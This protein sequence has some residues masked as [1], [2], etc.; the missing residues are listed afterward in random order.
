MAYT[1]CPNGNYFIKTYHELYDQ[2]TDI[3][4]YVFQRLDSNVV[5]LQN[6]VIET[7]AKHGA[8]TPMVKHSVFSCEGG[9]SVGG[10]FSYSKYLPNGELFTFLGG[11]FNAC[12]NRASWRAFDLA[13]AIVQNYKFKYTYNSRSFLVDRVEERIELGIPDGDKHVYKYEYINF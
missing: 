3:R 1:Y 6:R 4:S 13:G 10:L 12:Y 7:H 8:N 5:D 2:S 11:I 9:L